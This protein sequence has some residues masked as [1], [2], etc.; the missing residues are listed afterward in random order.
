VLLRPSPVVHLLNGSLGRE[1]RALATAAFAAEIQCAVKSSNFRLARQTIA[2]GKVPLAKASFAIFEAMWNR[3][4]GDEAQSRANS[5]MQ[6]RTSEEVGVARSSTS[7]V[8]AF[9]MYLPRPSL[10]LKQ[11]LTKNL[12][13]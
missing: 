4:A 2:Q 1:R 6:S 10:G 13:S 8:N 12:D 3:W 9:E 5:R 11:S 7:C